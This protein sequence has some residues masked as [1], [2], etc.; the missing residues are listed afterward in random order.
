MFHSNYYNHYVNKNNYKNFLM[1]SEINFQR[2]LV[3]RYVQNP[4]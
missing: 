4:K 3:K 1:D 2:Y